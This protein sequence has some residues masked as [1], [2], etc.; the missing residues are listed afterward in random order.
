MDSNILNAFLTLMG[1][2]AILGIILFMMK[3]L[4]LK[5]KKSS[6]INGIE[7]L[8]KLNLSPKN[9]L[10]TIKIQNRI[11]LLGVSEKSI[12]LLA[13]LSNSNLQNEKYELSNKKS[14]STNI[15][16]NI[17]DLSSELSFKEFLKNA[18][19]KSN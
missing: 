17:D 19:F 18:V 12:N 16:K 11:L 8:S 2:V 7:V 13:E 1:S 14:T 15:N 4:T 10:W 3:K 6:S 9:A 5:F